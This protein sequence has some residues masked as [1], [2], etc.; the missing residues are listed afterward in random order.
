MP[1]KKAA[2]LTAIF[3]FFFSW[4][5]HSFTRRLHYGLLH[6][7]ISN[8]FSVLIKL[9]L[10]TE[11]N[12]TAVVAL[13]QHCH[14]PFITQSIIYAHTHTHTHTRAERM[15]TETV[16]TRWITMTTA[17]HT[18]VQL[19]QISSK[20]T[21]TCASCISIVA[22]NLLYFNHNLTKNDP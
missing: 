20:Q 13:H 6:R 8:T 12:S 22:Q 2:K 16:I 18:T 7:N 1:D 15:M 19:T 17:Q 3:I 4:C 14:T 9:Y 21:Q 5:H 10:I 11:R